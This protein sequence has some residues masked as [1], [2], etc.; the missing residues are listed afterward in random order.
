MSAEPAKEFVL[1]KDK[2]RDNL[3]KSLLELCISNPVTVG[4]MVRLGYDLLRKAP[5]HPHFFG[6]N[7][8]LVT[9]QYLTFFALQLPHEYD[10][11]TTLNAP[12]K[13]KEVAEILKLFEI[14]INERIPV[15]YI[16]HESWYSG[17]KF[18]VNEHVLVPRSIMNTRF[19]DFLKDSQWENNRVLDLCTGS[20]CIGITLALLNPNLKVDLVDISPEA[21]KVASMNVNNHALNDRVECIESD[22]FKNIKNK[23]DLIITNPPYVTTS[24]YESSPEE[25][26]K[27][28]KIALECGDDGLEIIS[29]IL[30]EAKHFLNPNG[31]L[32]AEVGVTAAKRL[33]KKYP[34]VSFE[35]FT[36]RKPEGKESILDVFGM[37]CIFSCKAEELPSKAQNIEG[38]FST[39]LSRVMKKFK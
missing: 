13:E 35:W 24:E 12:I 29:R 10:D 3:Y 28:P 26:K 36:Y 11:P 16:T 9:A 37:H 6:N 15:E 23:Y 22:L 2:K 33:K 4:D 14:R 17:Y 31:K 38:K 39:L 5:L 18:Y 32:I 7:S 19:Q 25:F 30:S 1:S 8:L 34:E 20:G 21:L 27:E